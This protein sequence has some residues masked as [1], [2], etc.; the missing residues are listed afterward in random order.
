MV[1][2]LNNITNQ[3]TLETK[4]LESPNNEYYNSLYFKPSSLK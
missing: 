3:I 1:L 4:M 2:T